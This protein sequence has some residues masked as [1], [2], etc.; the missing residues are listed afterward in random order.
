MEMIFT[1]GVAKTEKLH[2]SIATIFSFFLFFS[3]FGTFYI[4][5]MPW[6]IA[7]YSVVVVQLFSKNIRFRFR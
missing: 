7:I 2:I 1:Y 3:F 6:E 5:E 4:N